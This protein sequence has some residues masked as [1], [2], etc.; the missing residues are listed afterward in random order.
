ME[1]V[2]DNKKEPFVGMRVFSCAFGEDKVAHEGGEDDE[3]VALGGEGTNAEQVAHSGEGAD[4][5]SSSSGTQPDKQVADENLIKY[6]FNE[7][8]KV[9]VGTVRFIGTLKNHPHPN[10]TFYGI[11]W[12]NKREGKNFGDFNSDVYFFPLHLLT[13]ERAK[14]CY[15]VGDRPLEDHPLANRKLA[16]RTSGI[17]AEESQKLVEELRSCKRHLKPCSFLPVEKIHVGLTFFQALHFRYT[18]FFTDSDLYVEDYQTKKTK[19]VQFNG[20]TEARNYFQNFHQLTN[21]TLNKYLIQTC[22]AHN[23]VAFHQLRSLS[24]CGNLLSQWKDIFEIVSLAKELSYLNVS[25]NKMEK[26]GLQSVRGSSPCGCPCGESE[27]K[28][29]HHRG[30]TAEPGGGP[31]KCSHCMQDHLIRFEQIKELCVDNTMID[32]EDV[33]ILSFVFPNVEILSLKRNYL[34]SIRMRD[35]DLV[36]SPVLLQYVQ[37]DRREGGAPPEEPSRLSLR[38]TAQQGGQGAPSV[39]SNESANGKANVAMNVP[40]NVSDVHTFRKLHKIVLND[41]YLHDYEDLFWFIRQVKSIRAV[42]LKRNKFADRDDLVALAEGVCSGGGQKGNQGEEGNQYEE[43]N[44]NEEDR[45]WEPREGDPPPDRLQRIN[46]RFSHL[47][48]LL[49]DENKIKSYKT[50]RDLFYAFYHLETLNYQ[51]GKNKLKV[52]KDLRFVFVAILPMLKTLN[53]SHINKSERIN[54]ERFF[55]SLYQKDDVVR[56]FNEPVLGCRHSDRLE[57]LHYEALQDQ[58]SA[59]AAKGMQSNL[60]N[61]TIIPE[62][63]NSKKYEIVKKKV[64]KHMNIKDLKYLCSRLYSVPLPKMQLFYTDENNPMCVEIVDSNSSLYTYGIDN[65]SKIK[66]KMEQ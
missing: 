46:E 9:K 17:P 20:I 44:Q 23:N 45:E 64:N 28:E 49:L 2:F 55:I 31:P 35:V 60:I 8:I 16:D 12:D 52:K 53:R 62:F 48:E 1:N 30:G 58:P 6:L 38:D 65:N 61:I 50:L 27:D 40:A 19:R 11:E 13:R 63:L 41:N 3:Q 57:C 24:L 42:F 34:T 15:N 47:K 39:E 5:K 54:S 51:R 56:V 22:G 59:D 43:G 10:T 29:G 26:L 14:R 33:L 18:Y 21:I 25:D 32:W 7:Q 4:N 37:R 36:N 66:I